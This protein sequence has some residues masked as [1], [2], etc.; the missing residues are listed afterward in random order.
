MVR[1]ISNKER[2]ERPKNMP[3]QKE[4]RA[5]LKRHPLS[6]ECTQNWEKG[7]PP[8]NSFAKRRC[9]VY[10]PTKRPVDLL[11]CASLEWKNSLW[12]QRRWWCHSMN[13]TELWD[14]FWIIEIVPV[15]KVRVQL[16]EGASALQEGSYVHEKK[17]IWWTFH[18]VVWWFFIGC[19][20]FTF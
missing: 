8:V 16:C 1:S 18:K 7:G 15:K 2:G 20:I 11:V 4:P 6:I 19:L 9:V 5:H 17:S 14:V 3:S 10:E 12:W 13:V